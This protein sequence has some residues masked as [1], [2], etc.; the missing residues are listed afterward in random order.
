ME[1]LGSVAEVNRS[2]RT[3]MGRYLYAIAPTG[4]EAVE[5]G[6]IGIESNRV[7]AISYRDICAV[8][9]DCTDTPYDSR[10]ESTVR[11]WVEVHHEVVETVK[12]RVGTVIPLVFDTIIR[13]AECADP[14]QMVKDWLR[15][16]YDKLKKS[17]ERFAGKDEYGIQIWVD[18]S[19]A[20]R[21][22]AK[23]SETLRQIGKEIAGKSPGVAYLL[24]Q[25]VEKVTK[26]ETEKLLNKWSAGFYCSIKNHSD[27]I[28]IEKTR[29]EGK[30]TLMVLNL[31]CLVE[32]GRVEALG[33]DLEKINNLE[34]F[35]VRFSGPWPP[36]SFASKT[37]RN[38]REN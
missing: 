19:S 12:A 2:I 11:A 20:S 27:D 32:K 33:E 7:Y 38:S 3:G 9:H 28:F 15:G 5:L 31:S 1:I 23:Q 8:V 30:G 14:D 34:G 16:D 36:Y 25:K 10:D 35:S 29:N 22:I 21:Q 18:S 24:K 4:S 17:L 13:S 37:A 6:F 26:S